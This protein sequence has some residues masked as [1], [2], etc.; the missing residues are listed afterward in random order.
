[1][2]LL[3]LDMSSYE[4]ELSGST[5]K[6]YGDGVLYSGWIPALALQQSQDFE[7]RA[8]IAESLVNVDVAA[9][10]LKMYAYQR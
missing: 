8:P 10:L 2:S 7:N 9:F 4:A 6:E 1:M 3:T 5:A